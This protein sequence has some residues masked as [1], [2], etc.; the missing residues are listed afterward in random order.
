MEPIIESIGEQTTREKGVRES[1][2]KSEN[3]QMK[4]KESNGM[5]S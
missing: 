3:K 5:N 4:I 1:K 2:E